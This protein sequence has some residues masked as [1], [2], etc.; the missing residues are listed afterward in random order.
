VKF[1]PRPFPTGLL[2]SLLLLMWVGQPRHGYAVLLWICV[3][4]AVAGLFNPRFSWI[5]LTL[6]V[7]GFLASLRGCNRGWH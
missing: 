4:L 5:A 3:A 6:V 2:G 1:E 7:V